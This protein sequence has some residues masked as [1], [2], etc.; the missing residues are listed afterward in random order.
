MS[1]I[2]RRDVAD[3]VVTIGPVAMVAVGVGEAVDLIIDAVAR[4]TSS[5]FAFCNMHT[6]NLAVSNRAFAQVLGAATVFNDGIGMNIASKLLF[7]RGFPAN[8]N[9]TDLTP[10]VLAS[11]PPGTGVFLLGSAP[12][13]AEQAGAALAVRHPHIRIAGCQHGFFAAEEGAAIAEQ[14]RLSGADLLLVGMGNPV[15][16]LWAAR[17]AAA[18]GA[19]TMCVGAFLDFSAGKFRRAPK[20]L[21]DIRLEWAYRIWLEPRRMFRRYFGGAI[22]FFSY[23]LRERSQSRATAG[24]S[25]KG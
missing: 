5:I 10:L 9:G 19:V 8:L 11:T 23:I 12:G 24:R 13:V 22:P 16:E 4:R 21:Q 18:T 3:A 2:E 25:R 6:L 7:G 14:V 1:R 17:Y 20:L 15:Q